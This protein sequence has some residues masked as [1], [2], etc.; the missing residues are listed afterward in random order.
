MN[1]HRSKKRKLS[2]LET[3][4]LVCAG[5]SLVGAGILH[6]WF[7]T[8]NGR[9]QR[10]ISGLGNEVKDFNAK[11]KRLEADIIEEQ[12]KLMMDAVL[13]GPSSPFEVTPANRLNDIHPFFQ[14]KSNEVSGSPHLA[15]GPALIASSP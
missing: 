14:I 15:Q 5:L 13:A 1:K 4:L 9:V 6:A 11:I 7:K 10:E 12:S 8:E 3:T 2:L